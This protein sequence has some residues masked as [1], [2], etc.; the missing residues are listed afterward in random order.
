MKR[1]LLASLMT[2]VVAVTA[3]T[4][5]SKSNS[6]NENI[7]TELKEP[8]TIE[9]WHYCDKKMLG[10]NSPSKIWIRQFAQFSSLKRDAKHSSFATRSRL[11]EVGSG[12]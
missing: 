7:V 5:C 6:S 8:V 9:M 2:A 3:L 11:D 4:G 12:T 1:R 10:S